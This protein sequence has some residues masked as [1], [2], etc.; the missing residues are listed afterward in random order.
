MVAH[1][2]TYQILHPFT[3]LTTSGFNVCAQEAMR[4]TPEPRLPER[5]NPAP[6]TGDNPRQPS[7]R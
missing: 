7:N 5:S 1:P 4:S 3:P 6:G 2:V